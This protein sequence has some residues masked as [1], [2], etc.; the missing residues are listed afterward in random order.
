M[1]SG[2]DV[3]H[4]RGPAPSSRYIATAG[5]SDREPSPRDGG[6]SLSPATI[7]NIMADL[8]EAGSSP[9]R[10]PPGSA[11]PR[12][13]VPDY[14]DQPPGAA[15]PRPRRDGPVAPRG[16]K[17]RPATSWCGR[18]AACCEPG[19]PDERRR[20]FLAG[21]AGP[22]LRDLMR[23]GVKDP[24]GHRDARRMGPAPP[25]R[26]R[27]GSHR[28]RAREDQRVPQRAGEGRTL[29]RCAPGS[30]KSSARRRPGTTA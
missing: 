6:Q 5:A 26:G 25:D 7:R 20:W 17:E 9:S 3:S 30:S 22:Q 27:A 4:A 19:P 11:S 1:A 14:I 10:T 23:A 28:R 29:P 15:I 24:V 13:R 12:A 16:A 2:M 21:T 8:E 18:S